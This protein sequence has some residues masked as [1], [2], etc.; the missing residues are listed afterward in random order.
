MSSLYI[1]AQTYGSGGYDSSAYNASSTTGTGSSGGS[2]TSTPGATGTSGGTLTNTGFDILLASSLAC[3]IIFAALLVR[4]WKR[5]ALE[6]ED[7]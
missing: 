7:S 4:F 1:F 5:P 2:G 3:A 6:R